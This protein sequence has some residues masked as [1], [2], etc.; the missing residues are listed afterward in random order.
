[1][2]QSTTNPQSKSSNALFLCLAAVVAVVIV[3]IGRAHV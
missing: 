1:M 2:A 3:Q